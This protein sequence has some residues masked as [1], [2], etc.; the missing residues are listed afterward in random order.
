MNTSRF[1]AILTAFLALALALASA[2]E[3]KVPVTVF[4]FKRAESDLY[5]GRYVAKGNFGKLVHGREMADIDHQDVVRMNRDT[6]YSAGV[7]DLD[8][9]PVT[10][11]LPDPGKRFMSM[12]VI[13]QDHYTTEVVYE[14][15]DHNY[16]KEKVGTRFVF[17]LIRTLAN[18]QD[19]KDMEAAHAIQDAIKVKQARAGK[20][21]APD[22]D[23][24]SRQEVRDA[25]AILGSHLGDA[26]L[27]SFG[28]KEEVDP[29][30]HLI[31]TSIGWGGNP[32]SAAVYQTVFPEKNDGNTAHT[33][34]VKDVPVDGFWSVS[35]YN[36]KGYFEKN[37]ANAYSLNNLT[38]KPEADGSFVIHFGGDKQAANYLPVSPGWNYIVRLYRPRKAILD[39]S[40]TFPKP[41]PVK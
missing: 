34:T 8:A 32:R 38:A 16:T 29:V 1:P 24:K 17:I 13:S 22:W 14:P 18:P 5:F 19:A 9:A 27:E 37:D 40:W 2:E 28:R 6:I 7:F 23:E 36:A 35:V 33:L 26:N 31:G 25:L 21:E 41:G 10:I 4:N 30:L 15:G 20:W 11:T 39:G 3:T 12:Q